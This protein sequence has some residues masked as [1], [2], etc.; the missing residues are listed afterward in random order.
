[1][2]VPLNF[3]MH[4]VLKS[5]FAFVAAAGVV[6]A[7]TFAL[8]ADS[9]APADSAPPPA[10][11]AASPSTEI[12]LFWTTL[13]GKPLAQTFQAGDPALSSAKPVADPTL[14]AAGWQAIQIS[15][16]FEG[17]VSVSTARKD[18][19]I[20]PGTAIHQ[21]ADMNSAVIGSAADQP[22]TSIVSV[23]GD[24][25]KVT[26]PGPATVYFQGPAA[27][28]TPPAADAPAPTPAVPA[29]KPAPVLP[30][31]VLAQPLTS[32]A[33]P[34]G[35]GSADLP[36]YIYG[37]LKLRTDTK[38]DGPPSAQYILVDGHGAIMA[39]VDLNRV[40]LTTPLNDY[41]GRFV[42][43]YGAVEANNGFPPVLLK[44]TLVQQ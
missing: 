13:P 36:R 44:A 41:L 16:N 30:P 4:A 12:K 32:A 34:L 22:P 27:P 14:A 11:P 21:D 33:T 1:M 26:M 15:G 3:A 5:C 7:P 18:L 43:V 8:A 10:A 35:G 24:W 37:I 9:A 29:A 23:G 2:P 6:L 19:T 20:I 25:A 17:Y 38:L 31:P 28:A 40:I 39:V 42:K